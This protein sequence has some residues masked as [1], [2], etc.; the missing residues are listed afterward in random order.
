MA[1]GPGGYSEEIGSLS[2][3]TLHIEGKG[4]KRSRLLKFGRTISF[5]P[6]CSIITAHQK[7]IDIGVEKIRSIG[8]DGV[9]KKRVRRWKP[10]D[11]NRRHGDCLNQKKRLPENNGL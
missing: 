8:K 2:I 6:Y 5:T 10:E 4:E 1:R 7:M 3:R 9:D 11:H